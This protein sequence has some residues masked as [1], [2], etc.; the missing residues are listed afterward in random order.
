MI[1]SRVLTC[2]GLGSFV[3][4]CLLVVV[5]SIEGIGRGIVDWGSI[6]LWVR[7]VH[8]MSD[9]E[10]F[11]WVSMASCGYFGTFGSFGSFGSFAAFDSFETFVAAFD[12]TLGSFDS[13]DSLDS[14]VDS[15]VVVVVVASLY[16]V[17]R[18]VYQR[19]RVSCSHLTGRLHVAAFVVWVSDTCMIVSLLVYRMGLT[20]LCHYYYYYLRVAFVVDRVTGMAERCHYSHID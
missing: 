2:F 9:I 16:R 8:R 1:G 17:W 19:V 12:V 18:P 5:V 4:E 11:Y 6:D 3:E 15:W 7:W 13:F 20:R 14:F 10:A